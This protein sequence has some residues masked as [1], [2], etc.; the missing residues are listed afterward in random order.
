MQEA[1]AACGGFLMSYG[2]ES[3]EESKCRVGE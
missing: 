2:Q 1:S 3:G